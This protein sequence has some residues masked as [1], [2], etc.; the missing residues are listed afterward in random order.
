MKQNYLSN[1]FTSK[2]KFFVP[3]AYKL[4]IINFFF[5]YS[6]KANI[7]NCW[8]KINF[9]ALS[10]GFVGDIALSRLENEQYEKELEQQEK[11]KQAQLAKKI[12]ASAKNTTE[13]AKK[14]HRNAKKLSRKNLRYYILEVLCKLLKVLFEKTKYPNFKLV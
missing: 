9:C 13:T 3:S 8:T 10:D 6:L 5:T 14:R 4:M 2:V 12:V 1:Y 11:E 7:L